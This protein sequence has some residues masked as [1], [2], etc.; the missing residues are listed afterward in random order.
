MADRTRIAPL[1]S[2]DYGSPDEETNRI[3]RRRY[4]TLPG[5]RVGIPG[6][7]DS[8]QAAPGIA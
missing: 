1:P 2:A 4:G 6:S 5:T 8:P 3:F 7:S